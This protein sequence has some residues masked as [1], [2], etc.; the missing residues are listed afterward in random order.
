MKGSKPRILAHMKMYGSIT[1]IE[2]YKK[3]GVT[4]LAAAIFDLRK[5]GY[6]IDTLMIDSENRYGEAVRYGKYIL[7]GEPSGNESISN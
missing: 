3:Y 4:R 1:S 6:E 5:L 2:A 7:K